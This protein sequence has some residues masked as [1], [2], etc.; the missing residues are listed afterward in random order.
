MF[1]PA[2]VGEPPPPLLPSPAQ[3]V[4]NSKTHQLSYPIRQGCVDN[5]N[6]MEKL[7]QRCFYDYLRVEPEEHYVLLVRAAARQAPHPHACAGRGV[8][9]ARLLTAPPPPSFIPQT[10]P[11]LNPPENREYTAE[12]MFETFNV[13]GMY[14]AVQAVLALAASWVSRK[15]EDRTLT[16]TVVDSGDGVTHVIPVAEGYVIGSCIRHIPLAGR[17]ITQFIQRM[18]RDRGEPVPPEDSLEVAKRIKERFSYVSQDIVKEYGKFDAEPAKCFK[19]FVGRN[20]RTRAEYAADVGYEQCVAGMWKGGERG[21]A[22]ARARSS[23]PPP[24]PLPAPVGSSPPS[25]SST[26]RSTRPTSPSRCPRWST[27]RSSAARSTSASSSTPTSCSPAARPCSPTST[28]ACSRTS[29]TACRSAS[30]PTGA[31][32]RSSNRRPT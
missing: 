4:A 2:A 29:S 25:S 26:P 3:A 12:V 14:I 30:P 6:N 23:A 5:W 11:P 13:P 1:D 7:W 20:A 9:A 24:L 21:A 10:E 18:L 8:S 17:D 31:S 16:G 32:T 27:S 19:R 15:P 28:A 22:R